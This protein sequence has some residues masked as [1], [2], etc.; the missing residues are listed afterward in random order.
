VNDVD[1]QAIVA[2]ATTVSVTEGTSTA[3]FTVRLTSAPA[4]T[5]SVSV[6]SGNTA[7][8]TAAPASLTFTTANYATPQTVTLTGVADTNAA[9]ETVTLTL[10]SA[11]IPNATVTATTVDTTSANCDPPGTSPTPTSG[12]HQP[13]NSCISASCHGKV[14][15]SLQPL[16]VAGT[17]YGSVTGGTAVAQATIHLIDSSN[18]PQ[19]IKVVTATNGNFWTSAP[20]VYPI[21]VRA[22]KCPNVDQSM[23]STVAS[24]GGNCNGCHSSGSNQGRIHLP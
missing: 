4:A 3:T 5:T 11:G 22:S 8:V 19:D 23:V 16:T 12:Q 2:S 24:S 1:T 21:R 18:P 13:G 14:Q 6:T 15:K 10:A 17:L 20:V 7:A 9:V